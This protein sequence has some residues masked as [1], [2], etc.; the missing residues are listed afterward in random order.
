MVYIALGAVVEV[1]TELGELGVA[2]QHAKRCE[3]AAPAVFTPY[4]FLAVG[5]IGCVPAGVLKSQ[6]SYLGVEVGF[7][8]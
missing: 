7:E 3:E 6:Q 2:V 8:L 5:E 4:D 1:V